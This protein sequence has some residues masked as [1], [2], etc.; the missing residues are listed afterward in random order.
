MNS[1]RRE[2]MESLSKELTVKIPVL[3][4]AAVIEFNETR[5]VWLEFPE[6]SE[7]IT[8]HTEIASIRGSRFTLQALEDMLYLNTKLDLTKGAWLGFHRDSG[9]LRLLATIPMPFATV[10]VIRNVME[11]L[12]ISA[13]DITPSLPLDA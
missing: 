3:D 5:E 4:G 2:L 12:V 1:A 9:T 13:D 8:L 11:N 7:M 10:K 6:A